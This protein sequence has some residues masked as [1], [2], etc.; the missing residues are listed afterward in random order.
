MSKMVQIR[1]M[2]EDLHRL[3]KSRAAASGLSLSDYLLAELRKS[4]ARPTLDDLRKRLERR[5]PAKLPTPPAAAVRAERD[6]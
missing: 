1:N 6:R 5:R 3:L 4:A 2:P